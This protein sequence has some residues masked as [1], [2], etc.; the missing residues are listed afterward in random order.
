M[1]NGI[2]ND[3]LGNTGSDGKI[4]YRW[5]LIYWPG[6][7]EIAKVYTEGYLKY[8]ENQWQNVEEKRYIA[9]LFRHLYAY[10]DGEIFDKEST[11]VKDVMH[12]AQVAWNSLAILYHIKMREEEKND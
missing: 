12:I 9:A 2:K 6:I 4:K 1:G 7:E 5:D 11:H 8:G 10:L 3:G